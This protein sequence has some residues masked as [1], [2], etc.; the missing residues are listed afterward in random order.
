MILCK[1]IKP[2]KEKRHMG[3]FFLSPPSCGEGLPERLSEGRVG[4][5]QR[6]PTPE[7]GESVAICSAYGRILPSPDAH[8]VRV[9]LFPRRGEGSCGFQLNPCLRG[10]TIRSNL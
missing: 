6:H 10:V 8:V 2:V 5:E 3:I 7:G 4:L 1:D 9:T